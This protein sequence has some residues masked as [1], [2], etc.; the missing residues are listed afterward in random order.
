MNQVERNTAAA[1]I[2]LLYILENLNTHLPLL[3]WLG[4]IKTTL[5]DLGQ[6][7]WESRWFL[8]QLNGA[9]TMDS[10]YWGRMAIATEA[11][12]ALVGQ[13]VVPSLQEMGKHLG[14]IQKGLQ[15]GRILSINVTATGVTTKEAA[16]ALGNQIAS[17]L[18]QQM[19]QTAF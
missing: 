10:S 11:T 16:T 9:L 15:A 19:V 18:Q 17:N 3:W 5:T 1:S 13:A 8:S 4:D 6:P 12:L 2:H 7:L 14:D